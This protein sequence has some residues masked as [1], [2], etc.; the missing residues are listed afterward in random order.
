MRKK[1][2]SLRKKRGMILIPAFTV[3]TVFVL[4]LFVRNSAWYYELFDFDA[5][6]FGKFLKKEKLDTGV[7]EIRS[8]YIV[9]KDGQKVEVKLPAEFWTMITDD[10]TKLSWEKAIKYRIHSISQPMDD[11]LIT[12]RCRTME[13]EI[14]SSKIDEPV[15]IKIYRE[16]YLRIGL[17]T[18]NE[19]RIGAAY[20]EKYY[21]E[22]LKFIYMEDE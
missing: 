21:Q 12:S 18:D 22:G 19:F 14:V 13:F 10:F 4:I 9:E 2:M 11:I 16:G 8:G 20:S 17:K 15:L 3:F 6:S 1:R 7:T 5:V